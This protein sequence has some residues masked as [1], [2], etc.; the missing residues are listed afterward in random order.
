MEHTYFLW[1]QR[2]IGLGVVVAILTAILIPKGYKLIA[3]LSLPAGAVVGTAWTLV[4][5]QLPHGSIME[6]DVR[7]FLVASVAGLLTVIAW[8]VVVVIRSRTA[9]RTTPAT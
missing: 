9:T 8:L 6:D 2:A 1:A 7:V 5:L 3:L 4:G